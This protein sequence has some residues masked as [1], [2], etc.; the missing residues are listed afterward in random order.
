VERRFVMEA[1]KRNDGNVTRA[2][3]E[4]GMQRPNFQALMRE[5]HITSPQSSP[6]AT[7][8]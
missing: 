6:R 7:D 2:A 1:L 4:V 5:H 8:S 3:A